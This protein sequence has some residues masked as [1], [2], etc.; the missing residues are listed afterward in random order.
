MPRGDGTGP[1]GQGTGTGRGM[2]SGGGQGRG[3]KGGNRPGSGP[4]G[5]C[6]CPK[7]GKKVP[8]RAGYPCYEME[9]PECGT[10]MVRE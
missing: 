9:C 2:G 8:H 4:S 10:Q 1:G 6:V 7:C 3:R 5:N